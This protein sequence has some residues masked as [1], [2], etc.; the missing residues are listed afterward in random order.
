MLN[1]FSLIKDIEK[2]ENQVC[3]NAADYTLWIKSRQFIDRL[4]AVY[5]TLCGIFKQID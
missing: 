3:S 2:P 5:F 4:K 1:T